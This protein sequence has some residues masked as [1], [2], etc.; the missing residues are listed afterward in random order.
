MEK[1]PE[2]QTIRI[3]VRTVDLLR[4]IAAMQK[5]SMIAILDRLVKVEWERV[6]QEERDKDI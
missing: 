5:E 6:K 1:T 2:Y 4:I 3:W